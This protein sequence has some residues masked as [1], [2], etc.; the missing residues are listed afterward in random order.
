MVNFITILGKLGYLLQNGFQRSNCEPKLYIKYNKQGNILIVC[1][2]LD[3]L[4][5]TGDFSIDVF[6]SAMNNEFEMADLGSMR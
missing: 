2:Y 3:Y 6:K 1:L 4:I 5:F